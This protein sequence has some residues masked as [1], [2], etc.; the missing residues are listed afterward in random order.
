M[1]R[2]LFAVFLIVASMTGI[3]AGPV[4]DADSVYERGD[5]ALAERLFRLLAE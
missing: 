5:C 4:E 2:I 1:Q 3:A